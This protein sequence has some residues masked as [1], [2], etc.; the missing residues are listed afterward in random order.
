MPVA[1]MTGNGDPATTK[2]ASK[3]IAINPANVHF[4][5]VR[6]GDDNEHSLIEQLEIPDYPMERINSEGGLEKVVEK[7]FDD[8]EEKSLKATGMPPF[9]IGQLDIDGFL[10]ASS[11]R[12]FKHF[13]SPGI[14]AFHV[15]LTGTPVG[16]FSPRNP[17]KGL[18]VQ[19]SIFGASWDSGLPQ[20]ESY[21]PFQD[22][23][24]T[25]LWP[26]FRD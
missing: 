3:Y 24:C 26:R 5:A 2:F 18:R 21:A 25:I 15:P 13:S 7:I 14:D 6:D 9:F 1:S 11:S 16:T 10:L 19:C 4:L 22:H 23:L 17:N 20:K 12:V 8:A